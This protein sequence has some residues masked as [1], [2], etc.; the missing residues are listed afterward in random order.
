[1][2]PLCK[3]NIYT[4]L[5]MCICYMC[6]DAHRGQKQ[7]QIPRAEVAGGCEQDDMVDRNKTASLEMQSML[8]TAEPHL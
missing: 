3:R 5:C 4:Y 6:Q 8:L 7:C 2:S 1:M